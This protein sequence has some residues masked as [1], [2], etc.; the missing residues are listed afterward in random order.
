M[1]E[2]LMYPRLPTPPSQETGE[3]A[4]H[5]GGRLVTWLLGQTALI[6]ATL[7][8][9]QVRRAHIAVTVALAQR[10]V[11]GVNGDRQE[12]PATVYDRLE[13]CRRILRA[14]LQGRGLTE[15]GELPASSP[16]PRAGA[17][18]NPADDASGG[19]GGSKVPRT[20]IAPRFPPSNGRVVPAGAGKVQIQF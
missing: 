9:R 18:G 17:P 8:D 15:Y 11:L 14:T 13:A 19:G 2:P 3:L 5:Y 4:D 7:D 12:T 1:H 6:T 10:I 16:E 20:P